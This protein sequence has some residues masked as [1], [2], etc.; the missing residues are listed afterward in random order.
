MRVA[1]NKEGDSNKGSRQVDGG[2][3]EEGDS[4]EDMIRGRRGRQ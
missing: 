2:G 3:N 1:G 4:N